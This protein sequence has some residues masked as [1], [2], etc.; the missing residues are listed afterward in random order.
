MVQYGAVLCSIAQYCAIIVQYCL[1]VWCSIVR[2]GAVILWAVWCS[3]MPY[4]VVL[5]CSTVQHLVQCSS[6][7]AVQYGAVIQCNL[8]QY[9]C[10]TA[11]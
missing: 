1:V 4:C 5:L 7:S 11:L 8:I 6:Y 10:Y 2:Y 9:I 3:M